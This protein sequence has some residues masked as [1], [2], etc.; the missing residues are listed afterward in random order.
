MVVVAE[1]DETEG[2]Q[3]PIGSRPHWTEHFGHAS[4]R[5]RLGL[6]GD[7]DEIPLAQTPGQPQQAAGHGYSLKLGFGALAIFQN[8]QGQN[9][10][11]KLNTGRAALRMHLGK[12][13]HRAN[14]FT[15]LLVRARYLRHMYRFPGA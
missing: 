5:A 7:L 2:L 1:R 11:A 3:G 9:G 14:Y 4:H 15:A 8:N 6:K 12:V 10:T 13:S